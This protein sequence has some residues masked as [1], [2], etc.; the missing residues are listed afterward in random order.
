MKIRIGMLRNTKKL[1]MIAL[2]F[3][4]FIASPSRRLRCDSKLPT[5]P[6]RDQNNAR[7]VIQ[8]LNDNEPDCPT[9]AENAQL[10]QQNRRRRLFRANVLFAGSM[11][12]YL[13]PLTSELLVYAAGNHADRFSFKP[14]TLSTGLPGGAAVSTA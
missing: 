14:S 7:I 11:N 2:S 3:G 6:K 1:A 13:G 12:G 5:A 9:I 10:Y 4:F 8:P